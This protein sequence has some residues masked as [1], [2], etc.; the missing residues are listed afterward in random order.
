VVEWCC[1]AVERGE[2]ARP[3][4]LAE[5]RA[6]LDRGLLIRCKRV[7]TRG[8]DALNGLRQRRLLQPTIREHPG[9]LLGIEGIPAR[10]LEK[11]CRQHRL[12]EQTGEEPLRLLLR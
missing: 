11:L 4:D 6:V 10:E 1:C 5:D 8:D 9:V 12:P 3:E 2:R 7:E